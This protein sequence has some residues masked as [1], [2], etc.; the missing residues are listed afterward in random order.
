MAEKRRSRPKDITQDREQLFKELRREVKAR[1]KERNRRQK[2][3][4][5]FFIVI[6]AVCLALTFIPKQ[7]VY[8]AEGEL[9]AGMKK[10]KGM[11]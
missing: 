4:S 3:L 5:L 9:P 1:R 2:A 8:P 7:P 10:P 11:R 6:I